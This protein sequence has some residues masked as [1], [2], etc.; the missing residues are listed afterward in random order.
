MPLTDTAI[1]QAKPTDKD[2]KLS[3]DRGLY[4]LVRASGSKLWRMDYRFDDKR[5]TLALG[6]YPDVSLAAARR[7]RDEARELI[8]AGTDPN[9]ARKD[10]EEAKRLAKENSFEAMARAWHKLHESEWVPTHAGKILRSLEANVFP[11]LGDKPVG[12]I[13][14]VDV[15]NVLRKVEARGAAD[16]VKRLRQRMADVFMYAIATGAATSNPADGLHKAVTPYRSTHRAALRVP[17]LRD[18]FIRLDAVRLGMPV[19][20][21]IRLQVLT[22]VRPG[23]LRCAMWQEFDLDA[24][25]W[26]VPAERDRARG[27]VGMKMREAHHVPLSRQVI[28]VLKELRDFSGHGDLVFP[29]RNDSARAMSDNTVNSGLR[30]MGYTSAQVSGAGFRTT[31]TGALLE[32]GYRPEV[33]DRQLSHRERKE[34]FGA[35]SHQVQYL[36]ERKKMMQA[37]ADYVDR[38]CK[39]ADVLPM[40]PRRKMPRG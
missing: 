25:M 9:Q 8:A 39:G 32:L 6:S 33:I 38:V 16:M 13:S 4:L 28:A 19:K 23:E 31:A 5:K 27:L 37:W 24:G 15:L 1:R 14:A 18:F 29:N 36:A 12:E 21:A 40:E 2:R 10:E 30:A 34:V 17:D 35:Y 3:D 7:L 11:S 20:H 26:I 22:F